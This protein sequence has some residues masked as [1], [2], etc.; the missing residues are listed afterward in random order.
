LIAIALCWAWPASGAVEV[1]AGGLVALGIAV[2]LLVLSLPFGAGA[3]G[4]G[5]VKMIV[6]IGFVT[7]L[8]GVAVGVILGTLA[9]AV[10][11]IALIGLR[12]VGRRDYIPHGPFLALGGVVAMLWGEEIWDWYRN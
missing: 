12:I 10:A 11:I 3:F 7:G 2:A 5:D 1:L 8:P 9:A 4:M 6:L